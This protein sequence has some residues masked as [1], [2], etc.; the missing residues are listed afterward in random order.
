MGFLDKMK[1]VV[2]IGGVK[3]QLA[4]PAEIQREALK[5]AGTVTLTSKT[6]QHIKDVAVELKEVFI[7]KTGETQTSKDYILGHATIIEN[8]DIKAG[9]T[10]TISFNCP[11]T[12]NSYEFSRKQAEKISSDVG[13]KLDSLFNN[14]K[15]VFTVSAIASIKGTL[16][17]STAVENVK[18]VGNTPGSLGDVINKASGK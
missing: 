4:V 2:G 6:D 10:K 1:Q 17:G 11:F 5:F 15:S 12:F 18:L 9:E 7:T 14:Q 13:R 8:Y 16:L 3:V